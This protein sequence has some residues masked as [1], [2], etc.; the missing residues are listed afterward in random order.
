MITLYD[1]GPSQYPADLG[2][3]PHTRK[4]IFTLN[5]KNIPFELKVIRPEDIEAISKSLGVAH[6]SVLSDGTPRYTIPFIIDST[7]E[8]A[9]SDSLRIAEYLDEAY[10]DTPRVFPEGTRV[11]QS[12]FVN[13]VQARIGLLYPLV[14]RQ[15]ETL[16]PGLLDSRKKAYGGGPDSP[17]PNIPDLTE[18]Q[19]KEMWAGVKTSFTELEAAYGGAQKDQLWVM[20]DKP[21]FAD[22]VLAVFFVTLKI[23]YGEQS[24]EWK[25]TS[26]LMGGRIG[27]LSEEVLKYRSPVA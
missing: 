2:T 21:V 5:Y 19:K 17:Y 13:A 6:S 12:V 25:D 22:F 14:F 20:G 8:K 24:Q 26:G 10:P 1:M 16:S 9:V 4:I 18:A 15:F 23:A 3:S 11:L 27:K 7:K